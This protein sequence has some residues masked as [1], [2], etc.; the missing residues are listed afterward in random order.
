MCFV[1]SA[2]RCWLI[3]ESTVSADHEAVFQDLFRALW[4]TINVDHDRD[5]VP[6]L[7]GVT[8]IDFEAYVTSYSDFLLCVYSFL[9]FVTVGTG[10]QLLDSAKSDVEELR[11]GC[12]EDKGRERKFT[13]KGIDNYVILALVDQLRKTTD[14]SLPAS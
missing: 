13:E 2:R 14:Y 8:D 4:T 9:S 7:T 10:E 1:L 12:R 6:V 5:G 11:K 3:L